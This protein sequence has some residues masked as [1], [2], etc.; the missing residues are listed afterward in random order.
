DL[1]SVKTKM[2]QPPHLERARQENSAN[3]ILLRCD[4]HRRVLLVFWDPSPLP[5]SLRLRRQRGHSLT[6]P[7]SPR[8]RRRRAASLRAAL[9]STWLAKAPLEFAQ[10]FVGM[11][12]VMAQQDQCVE[13]QVS[14][15]V[16]N[17]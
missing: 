12:G 5:L 11:D 3:V 13:P 6:C 9:P 16:D 14:H 10:D 8:L 17:L 7:R 4:C 15:L 1:H 2:A